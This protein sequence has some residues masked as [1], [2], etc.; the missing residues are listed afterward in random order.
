M[1]DRGSAPPVGSGVGTHWLAG[2]LEDG[3]HRGGARQQ[4]GWAQSDLH[5]DQHGRKQRISLT[6][7]GA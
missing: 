7:A 3:G 2:C 1:S 4:S 5:E 6:D